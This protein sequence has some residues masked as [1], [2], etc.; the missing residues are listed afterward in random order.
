[1]SPQIINDDG[2]DVIINADNLSKDIDEHRQ[3]VNKLKQDDGQSQV[4]NK[5]SYKYNP[6]WDIAQSKFKDN[7]IEFE[8]PEA[9]KLGKIEDKDLTPEDEFNLLQESIIQNTKFGFEE[10]PVVNYYLFAKERNPDLNSMDIIEEYKTSMKIH[11]MDEDDFLSNYLKASQKDISETEIQET[12]HKL[13]NKKQEVVEQL[14]QEVLKD[15]YETHDSINKQK[16]QEY[17]QYMSQFD[18]KRES[19]INVL[20]TEVS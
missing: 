1:M 17:E 10:D 7:G 5:D 11:S 15:F 6:L 20:L 9:L 14:K 16:A 12:I 13:G 3:F 4:E 19:E 8:L 2:I 18:K